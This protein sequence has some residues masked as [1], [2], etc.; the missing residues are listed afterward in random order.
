[1]MTTMMTILKKDDEEGDDDDDDHPRKIWSATAFWSKADD[2]DQFPTETKEKDIIT[3]LFRT[4][5][6]GHYEL[7]VIISS[8]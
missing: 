5:K 4:R 8:C 6:R 3:S 2:S 7:S 1:M